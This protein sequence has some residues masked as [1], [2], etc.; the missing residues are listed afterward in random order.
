[1][2]S[3]NQNFL[4]PGVF[5]VQIVLLLHTMTKT[6][7]RSL[8][9]ACIYI[10]LQRIW[11]SIF[12]YQ[13][14]YICSKKVCTCICSCYGSFR[15]RLEFLLYCFDFCEQAVV[16]KKQKVV[17]KKVSRFSKVVRKPSHGRQGVTSRGQ[18]G[19]SPDCPGNQAWAFTRVS[20]CAQAFSGCPSHLCHPLVLLTL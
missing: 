6:F 5:P 18:A 13:L 2:S 7:H 16:E 11:K 8:V 1:M 19:E 9:F 14:S 20:V 10:E 4:H 15:L 17:F 3:D 12:L